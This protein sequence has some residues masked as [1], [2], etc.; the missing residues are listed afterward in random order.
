MQE[1]K[2]STISHIGYDENAKKLMVRFKSGGEYHYM[3]VPKETHESLM[4]A[5]SPG[6]FLNANVKNI[7]KFVKL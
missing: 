6:K 1:V 4:K 7:F 5:E 2:S 3:D